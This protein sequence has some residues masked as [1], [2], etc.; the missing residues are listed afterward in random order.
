MDDVLLCAALSALHHTGIGLRVLE[1]CLWEV[2]HVM[3]CMLPNRGMHSVESHVLSTRKTAVLKGLARKWR[4]RWAGTACYTCHVYLS[5][6]VCRMYLSLSG[7]P[8]TLMR[9]S[10]P[11][12]RLQLLWS[13]RMEPITRRPCC[14]AGSCQAMHLSWQLEALWLRR[15]LM[16]EVFGESMKYAIFV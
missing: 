3:L 5:M 8:L 14:T 11:T 16:R 2:H 4:H 12:W 10:M 13:F 7:T 9:K 15:H 1:R 6:A